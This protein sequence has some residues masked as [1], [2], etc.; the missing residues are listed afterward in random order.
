MDK[1]PGMLEVFFDMIIIG[2]EHLK[3][4]VL[5]STGRYP[6]SRESSYSIDYG[7][8]M[9]RP[10]FPDGQTGQDCQ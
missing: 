2:F 4:R 10:G 3:L 7:F 6:G 8:T 5:V 1:I 9:V